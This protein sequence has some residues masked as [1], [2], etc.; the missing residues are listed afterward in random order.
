MEVYILI[1]P[2]F[3]EN[4]NDIYHYLKITD[5]SH[6][7]ILHAFQEGIVLKNNVKCYIEADRIIKDLNELQSGNR[8]FRGILYTNGFFVN[9]YTHVLI[10]VSRDYNLLH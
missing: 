4:P 3:R 8:N 2:I 9:E 6:D 7:G 5:I 10:R 1:N